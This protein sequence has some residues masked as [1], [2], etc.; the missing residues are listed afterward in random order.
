MD[1]MTDAT[2]G[3]PSQT[4]TDDGE[5]FQAKDHLGRV[6]MFCGNE[7][8]NVSTD[9]GDATVSDTSLI[10]ILDAPGGTQ[11]F[12]NSWIFG[13]SLAPTL[14]KSPADVVVGVLGQ[15]EA[16]PGKSAPWKLLD[17]DDA[18]LDAARAVYIKNVVQS[19]SE[20][21]WAPDQAPF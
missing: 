18:Q 12:H 14:Y 10:V 1:R 21:L 13:A 4:P 9:F 6:V 2:F 11:V 19:G 16:K 20:F 5:K 15:G 17:C 8:R 3:K 7:K